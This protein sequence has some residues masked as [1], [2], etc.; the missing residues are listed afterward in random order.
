MHPP[1]PLLYTEVEVDGS[2]YGVISIPPSRH[3][4]HPTRNLDTPK[5]GWRKNEVRT[6]YRDEVQVSHYREIA[7][8]PTFRV[9]RN[10][11]SAAS[12]PRGHVQEAWLRCIG[13]RDTRLNRDVAIKLPLLRTSRATLF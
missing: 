4:H 13:A 5:G 7:G 11:D 8:C 12:N 6:R 1:I 9:F 3:V 2:V 10:V